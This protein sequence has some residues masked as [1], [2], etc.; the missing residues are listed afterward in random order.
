[1]TQSAFLIMIASLIGFAS[2]FYQKSSVKKPKKR[3]SSIRK[4]TG[5]KSLTMLSS[6]KNKMTVLATL[7]QITGM[8]YNTAQ[9]VINNTP[10]T[11]M[12]NIS[13]QE[14]S[15]TKQALEFVGASVEIK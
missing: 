5:D 9:R 12:T 13:E 8:D 11:F 4:T 2:Y 1:M 15:V 14:A 10:S 6:G 7:R 3:V